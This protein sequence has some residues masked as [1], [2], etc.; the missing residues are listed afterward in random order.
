MNKF[1]RVEK[2]VCQQL[3]VSPT[4]AACA[5]AVALGRAVPLTATPGGDLAGK[6]LRD[7]EIRA[8]T[9]AA[10]GASPQGLADVLRRLAA[11][12]PN[13]YVIVAHFGTDAGTFSVFV[14]EAT[15]EVVGCVALPRRTR[16]DVPSG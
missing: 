7:F 12:P 8:S 2:L 9:A 6:L 4:V 3:A 14:R 11:V 10:A 16:P 15:D 13:E 1:E 5:D